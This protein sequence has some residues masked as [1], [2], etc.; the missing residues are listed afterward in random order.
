[1]ISEGSV[2][3]LN[4]F[5][6]GDP[7]MSPTVKEV[8]LIDMPGPKIEGISVGASVDDLEKRLG[9]PLHVTQNPETAEKTYSYADD[10]YRIDFRVNLSKVRIITIS[11]RG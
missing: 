3:S 4:F 7:T 6:P 1:V 8:I 2:E 9:K 10:L 5:K 11:K